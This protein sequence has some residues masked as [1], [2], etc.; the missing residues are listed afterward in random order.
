M[1]NDLPDGNA[2]EAAGAAKAAGSDW[3]ETFRT[4]VYALGIAVLIRTFAYE[5]FSIPSGSMIPT[6]LI[7]DHL[8]VSK[9]SYG[10][11]R[12]SLPFGLPLIPGRILFSEPQRG[13]VA[14][15]RKPTD[16]SQ[17][18]IKRLIGLPG[19]RLQV[20][21]GILHI[22]GEPV[23]RK[24]IE[25][26]VDHSTDGN[27]RRIPQY[28]E[29]LPNGVEHRILEAWGDHGPADNTEVFI[30]PEGHYFGMGDNRDN[31]TDSRFPDVGFIP[32]ENL[33]GRADLMF[34]SKTD[35]MAWY[36]VWKLFGSLRYDRFFMGIH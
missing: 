28:I 2:S 7:G 5:P 32:V 24:R 10:Y 11:S 4:V 26:F 34:F 9:L 8:F 17:D 29:T 27:V 21:R 1:M 14:V 31:S 33:V 19:D 20:V 3:G 35:D 12:Y 25:D 6:L 22:N 23:V 13:D 18:Y 30:V 15:F 36:E 16:T